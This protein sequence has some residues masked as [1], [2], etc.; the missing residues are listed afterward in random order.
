LRLT[1][2][3]RPR[4]AGS[5]RKSDLRMCVEITSRGRLEKRSSAGSVSTS[6]G[7]AEGIANEEV[8]LKSM[9]LACVVRACLCAATRSGV[10]SVFLGRYC[11]RRQDRRMM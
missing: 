8:C 10:A 4:S 5:G 7:V 9:S 2:R 1:A 6:I 3:S 11:Q